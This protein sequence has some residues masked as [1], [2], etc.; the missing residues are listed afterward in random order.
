M[1]HYS[2]LRQCPSWT[3]NV[4]KQL[5]LLKSALY[6]CAGLQLC[7]PY[8]QH[9]TNNVLWNSPYAD[10]AVFISQKIATQC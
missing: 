8:S 7:H 10:A 5:S 4:I 6:R 1:N 2:N 9:E 3:I